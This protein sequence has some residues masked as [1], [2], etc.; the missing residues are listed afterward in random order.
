MCRTFLESATTFD[1][2]GRALELVYAANLAGAV[3]AAVGIAR[4]ARWGWIA[5]LAVVA[6]S[7]R[8]MSHR[9]QSACLGY[10]RTGLQRMQ[11]HAA[12]TYVTSTRTAT[13]RL[14]QRDGRRAGFSVLDS[15]T[16]CG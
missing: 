10:Q 6:L 13:I 7:F 11:R 4:N 12:I 5:G 1:A 2:A 9:R 15:D 14:A 3:A 16:D 8:S